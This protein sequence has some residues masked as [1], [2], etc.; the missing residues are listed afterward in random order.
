ME[1]GGEGFGTLDEVGVGE[2]VAGGGVDEEGS[3]G[4]GVRGEVE[5][6]EDV[7]GDGKGLGRGRENDRWTEAV[8]GTC[9]RAVAAVGF[10]SVAELGH[11]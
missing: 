6:V 8:E 2:G 11:W 9:L 1:I 5:E 4:G 3:G 10:D 7:V